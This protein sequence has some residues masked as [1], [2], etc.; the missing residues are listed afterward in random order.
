MTAADIERLFEPFFRTDAAQA[1][2]IQ[3][4]GLGLPIVKAI[5]EAHDGTITITSEPNIGTSFAISLPLAHPLLTH[6]GDSQAERL[7]AA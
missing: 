1:K 3:G 7:V 4:T 6:A 2:Q 5:V